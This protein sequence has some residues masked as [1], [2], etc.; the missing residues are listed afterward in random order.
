MDDRVES[1][2]LSAP[3][4]PPWQKIR[5][6]EVCGRDPSLSLSLQMVAGG[7]NGLPSWRRAGWQWL[8]L[9]VAAKKGGTQLMILVVWHCYLMGVTLIPIL[10][11]L[12]YHPWGGLC[13]SIKTFTD[14]LVRGWQMSCQAWWGSRGWKRSRRKWWLRQFVARYIFRLFRGS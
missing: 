13:R 1:L 5:G 11:M 4:P 9:P 8:R 14:S 2:L 6:Q 3:P 7:D 12:L 10:P